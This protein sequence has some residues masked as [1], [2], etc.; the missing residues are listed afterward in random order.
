MTQKTKEVLGRLG[1]E[2]KNSGVCTGRAWFSGKGEKTVSESPIDSKPIATVI[3]AS[4]DD[5]EKV[6]RTAVKG[7]DSW[8]R[9]P[10]PL[11]GEVVRQIGLAL[12]GRKQDLPASSRTKWGRYTRRL[13]ARYRR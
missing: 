3:N 9:V 2:A 8:K 10:T 6:I 5:L 7:F 4:H 1:I 12:S 13:S 11:R